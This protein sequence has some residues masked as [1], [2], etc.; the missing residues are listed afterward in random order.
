M[1]STIVIRAAVAFCLALLV[2]LPSFGTDFDDE[3]RSA[4]ALIDKGRFKTAVGKLRKLARDQNATDLVRNQARLLMATAHRL[5]GKPDEA[6]K[7]LDAIAVGRPDGYFL[8]L[9]ETYL[10][11]ERFDKAVSVSNCYSRDP[12]NPTILDAK[13]LWLKARA[14][15]KLEKYLGC[16]RE[17]RGLLRFR[18]KKT[19]ASLADSE[20]TEDHD[21]LL[22]ELKEKAA[23]LMKEA[24]YLH[25]VKRYGEDFAWYRKGRQA[26]FAKDCETAIE[27]YAKISGGVLRDAGRC[28]SG[29]C[30]E[31]LGRTKEALDV[32][33]NLIDDDFTGFYR[34]EAIHRSAVLRFKEGRKSD[35]REALKLT[36]RLREW[37]AAVKKLE[38]KRELE[39]INDALR[40]DVIDKAPRDFLK[41]GDC[42]NLIRNVQYP[43]NIDNRSTAPW[44]LEYLTVKNEL[45][46][47]FLLANKG[48]ETE[49]ALTFRDAGNKRIISDPGTIPALLDGLARGFPLLPAE[50]AKKL[51]KDERNL[52]S[53]ACFFH[54]TEEG[55]ASDEIVDSLLA[56][57]DVKGYDRGAATLLKAYRLVAEKRFK[58]AVAVL[59][60][61]VTNP[62]ALRTDLGGRAAFLQ[63]CLLAS[64]PKSS[65]TAYSIFESL[66]KRKNREL[67]ADAALAHAIAAV[68]NGDKKTALDA[69]KDVGRKFHGSP[70]ADAAATLKQA[71]IK[72]K[73]DQ[74]AGV[75]ETKSGKIV[76]HKR[77]LVIPGTSKWRVDPSD[78]RAGDLVLYR[79]RCVARDPCSTI[80]AVTLTVS[81]DEP[82][83]PT[84]KGNEIVFVRSPLLYVKNLKRGFIEKFPEL[85]GSNSL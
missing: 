7:I 69:C 80:K 51:S 77:T 14:I 67:A 21:A 66:R 22:A 59:N 2:A 36:F 19:I 56:D 29:R 84:A 32:Y 85:I 27:C 23:E 25:D 81:G 55:K 60:S 45:F 39:G 68:N 78:L 35:K 65:A 54:L 12:R 15:F 34:G 46:H 57:E 38:I 18:F 5:N 49:A 20:G 31:R 75:V 83:P 28:Y 43:E 13:A 72:S 58:N 47:G 37:L 42:G 6:A 73:K 26:Q 61:I 4:E 50:C 53:L 63:A 16:I 30:L 11:Q 62:K 79:I 10:D 44:Y 40:E 70:H 24:Q 8:E 71:I 82:Q 48:D 52:I 3:L 33:E 17:C 9:G 74:I 1:T 64:D 41:P 76:K